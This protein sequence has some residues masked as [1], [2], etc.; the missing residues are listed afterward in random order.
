MSKQ[1][2]K[3]FTVIRADF[4]NVPEKNLVY[5]R[6]SLTRFASANFGRVMCSDDCGFFFL[7]LEGPKVSILQRIFEVNGAVASVRLVSSAFFDKL[8]AGEVVG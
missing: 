6:G 8:F 1:Q 7:D 4:S 2:Q 3:T 5:L